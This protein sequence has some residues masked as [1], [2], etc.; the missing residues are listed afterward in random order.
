MTD[1]SLKKVSLELSI[2]YKEG[3]NRI[4]DKTCAERKLK[5]IL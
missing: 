4:V 3:A 1:L 2:S 5:K